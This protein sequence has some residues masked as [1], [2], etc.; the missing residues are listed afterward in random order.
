MCTPKYLYNIYLKL[1]TQM[2]MVIPM[3]SVNTAII[4][5]TGE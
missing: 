3:N 5:S 2:C 1:Y 4:S